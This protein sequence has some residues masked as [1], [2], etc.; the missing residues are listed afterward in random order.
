MRRAAAGPP[1]Q[2]ADVALILVGQTELWDRPSR[3]AY[4]ATR[5]RIDLQCRVSYLDRAQTGPY[6]QARLTYAGT[7]QPIFAAS[8]LDAIY[9]YSSGAARLINKVG[10]HALL[11]GAQNGPR[12][13]DEPLVT[14]VIQ[15]ELA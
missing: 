1:Q 13:L 12:L 6:V 14:R 15:G 3:Q 10:T 9:R 7:T 8:A 4:T 5:Q 11:Y 2:G